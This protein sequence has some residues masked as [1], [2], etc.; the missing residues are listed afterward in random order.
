M[1]EGDAMRGNESNRN[2]RDC[3]ADIYRCWLMFGICFLHSVIFGGHVRPWL[4]NIFEPCVDGFVFISGYYGIRFAW[5]KMLKL[6]GVSLFCAVLSVVFYGLAVTGF[7]DAGEFT[8]AVFRRSLSHWFLN[9][10]F[11]LM[12]L[13]P[14]LNAAIDSQVRSSLKS[15]LVPFL[16]LAFAWNWMGGYLQ[17]LDIPIPMPSGFGSYTVLMMVVVYVLA[18]LFRRAEMFIHFKT[19]WVILFFSVCAFACA[20]GFGEY[21]SPF[22]MGL[23][24]GGF[25]LFKRVRWPNWI[26]RFARWLG[27][28]MFSVY[29][30]HAEKE[31]QWVISTLKENLIVGVNLNVYAAYILIAIIVFWGCLVVDVCVRRLGRKLILGKAV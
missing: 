3:A 17:R 21:S 26:G 1:N 20:I 14:L 29:I 28:S 31:G 2:K 4:A 27:L 7:G 16:F 9:D 25:V 19:W 8:A 5:S 10:Y 12:L 13:A 11:V 18:R 24:I 15:A 6:Y 23:A 22:A 30:L